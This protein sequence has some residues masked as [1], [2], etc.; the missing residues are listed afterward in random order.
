M[1]KMKDSGIEWL[2]EIPE[3]WETN[4]MKYLFTNGKGLSITKENLIE[5]GLPV[6]SYGQIHS[7]DNSG[8][9]IKEHLLRY[10]DY[11]YQVIYPQCKVFQYDFVFAD[12]SED[13]DGC[14]NCVYKRDN[15]LLF[16]GYHTIIIHYIKKIIGIMHIFSRPIVGEN[17]FV[18]LLR[19]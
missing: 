17:R 12:T 4:R 15:S 19:V 16:G 6:I 13:Y 11:Q 9:Y 8:T 3:H 18:R 10:V 5:T 1:I 14:G 2:G 7:K